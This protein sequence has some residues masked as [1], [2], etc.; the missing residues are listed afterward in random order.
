MWWALVGLVGCVDGTAPAHPGDA[1]EVPF[2]VPEGSSFNGIGPRLV[3]AELEPAE[4]QWKWFLRSADAS[5]LKAGR[6]TLRRDMSM[7]DIRSTLCAAPLPDVL[8]SAQP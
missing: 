6:F 4:W 1:T 8:R 7:E 2:E 5:C 3:E